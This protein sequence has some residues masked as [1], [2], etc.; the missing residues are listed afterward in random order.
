VRLGADDAAL[1]RTA[2]GLAVDDLAADASAEASSAE[3]QDRQVQGLVRMAD[4][5]VAYRVETPAGRPGA[6]RHQLM[7]V[8]REEPASPEGHIAEIPDHGAVGH[9][10]HKCLERLACDTTLVDADMGRKQRVVSGPMRW[11]LMARDGGCRFPSCN[12]RKWVDA[13]PIIPWMNGGP[14]P[15]TTS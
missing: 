7:V 12:Q 3:F 6:D 5:F 15:G 2:L 10:A 14:R 11:A 8:L 9:I 4:A 1:L 13:H